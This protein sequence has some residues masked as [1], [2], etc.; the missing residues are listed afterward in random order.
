MPNHRLNPKAPQVP[1]HNAGIPA[2]DSGP[3]LKT[4]KSDVDTIK[5]ILLTGA[6][7]VVLVAIPVFYILQKVITFDMLDKNWSIISTIEPRILK[8]V[9]EEVDTAYS[10]SV[11]VSPSG[12]PETDNA[13][14]FYAAKGQEVTLKLDVQEL[15][16]GS[17]Q[18]VSVQVNG[19][20][21]L[22]KH[23]ERQYTHELGLDL[24]QSL[25]DCPAGENGIDLNTLRIVIPDAVRRTTKMSVECVVL[26]HQRVRGHFVETK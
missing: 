14:L 18:P 24:T 6:V 19:S 2:Q 5:L 4:I 23:G 8:N 25:H 13:I 22:P 21:V 1:P 15:Q 12:S 10:K 16:D 26:V 3:S 11:V 20:C 9:S 17:V 7:V